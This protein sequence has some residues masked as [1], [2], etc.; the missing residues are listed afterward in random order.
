M[1]DRGKEAV[2]A[3]FRDRT[4]NIIFKQVANS[5]NRLW[6]RCNLFDVGIF[7]V[8]LRN[9][10]LRNQIWLN[11]SMYPSK[12]IP[13]NYWSNFSRNLNPEKIISIR[14]LEKLWHSN[15]AEI[16]L[17]RMSPQRI[18]PKVLCLTDILTSLF[19]HSR[20][21]ICS[22][23]R[24]GGSGICS[25]PCLCWGFSHHLRMW[26]SPQGPTWWGMEVGRLQWGCGVWKHGVPGVCWCEGKSTGCTLSHEPP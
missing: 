8:G 13:N 23:Y 11:T 7:L 9:I 17:R 6:S 2:L 19:S 12:Q 3:W 22:C 24:L 10:C 18:F 1:S 4:V 25:D 14:N 20:V 16:F 15:S 5:S 21:S 26:H